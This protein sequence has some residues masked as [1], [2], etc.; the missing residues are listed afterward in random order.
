MAE[1]RMAVAFQFAV[2]DEGVNIH[3]DK[4][5][6]LGV[7]EAAFRS[8][9]RRYYR[10]RNRLAYGMFPSTPLSLLA[11]VLAVLVG[12]YFQLDPLGYR[13]HVQSMGQKLP[14]WVT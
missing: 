4:R 1:A 7:L 5:A 10:I 14:G 13:V 9:K 2:T 8:Y 6:A 12:C 3:L 11:L